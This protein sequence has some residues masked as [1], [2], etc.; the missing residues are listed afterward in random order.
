MAFTVNFYSLSKRENSTKRPTGDGSQ[1]SCNIKMPSGVLN[2]VIE[3]STTTNMTQY[4]YCKI[5][6]FQNRYYFVSDWVSDHGLWIAHLKV[7]VLATYKT[8]IN[9][10]TQYVVRSAS[11]ANHSIPDTAYPMTS[12][13]TITSTYVNN[14]VKLQSNQIDFVLGVLN[15]DQT[16]NSK[17]NGIQY[18]IMSESELRDFTNRLLT[19]NYFDLDPIL[20][21][22]GVNYK[23]MHAIYNGAQYIVESYMLPH[24]AMG[25]VTVS[26]VVV[27]PFKMAS[28][29]NV[30]AIATGYAHNV[31]SFTGGSFT[32]PTHPQTQDHGLYVNNSPYSH[33]VLHA[34]PFGD[35][36]LDFIPATTQPTVK[37]TVKMDFKGDAQLLLMDNDDHLLTS[38][39]ANLSVPIPMISTTDRGMIGEGAIVSEV[40]SGVL[41]MSTSLLSGNFYDRMTSAVSDL[42]PRPNMSGSSHGVLSVNQDWWLSSEFYKVAGNI[43][44]GGSMA[45]GKI[46]QPLCEAITLSNLNGFCQ[47]DN[48]VDIS[49]AAYDSEISQVR[50]LMQ[51]GFFLED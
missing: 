24:S 30:K 25:S 37:Y 7:D 5:V 29:S 48:Q 27:G 3:L 36:P 49:L 40:G 38:A 32:I 26:D 17:I 19:E 21:A 20:Q 11:M 23:F 31:T 4:N 35:I 2:P 42:I 51:S 45:G 12:E 9:A 46:G 6:H 50:S 14:P 16:A 18:L 8:E 47:C 39:Y 34:G 33:H 13:R 43:V 28:P 1:F 10:S 15:Y 41:S 44:S 22:L